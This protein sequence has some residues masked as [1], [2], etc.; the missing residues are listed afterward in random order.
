M[1]NTIPTIAAP[2]D[3]RA[4]SGETIQTNTFQLGKSRYDLNTY[5]GRVRHFFNII[6]PRTLFTTDEQLKKA[7]ALLDAYRDNRLHPGVGTEELWQAQKIVQAIIHPDTGQKIPMPF[8]MSGYV[9][10]GAYIT[11]YAP[12]N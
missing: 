8:R 11:L 7:Q 1:A 9:P 5:T 12:H 6:D 2:Y 3:S 10:F 4:S